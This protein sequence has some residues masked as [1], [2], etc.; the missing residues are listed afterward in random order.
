MHLPVYSA[1]FAARTPPRA[2]ACLTRLRAEF[3]R[4]FGLDSDL[5]LGRVVATIDTSQNGSV[6]LREFLGACSAQA[7]AVPVRAWLTRPRAS[8]AGMS[9]FHSFSKEDRDKRVRR[10][11]FNMMDVTGSGII[12][13]VRWSKEHGR[14]GAA[15]ARLFVCHHFDVS[16]AQEHLKRFAALAY[17]QFTDATSVRAASVRAH[18]HDQR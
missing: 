18:T 11:A 15:L 10:F 4:Q 3:S 16:F 2:A 14:R 12:E 6:D 13:R 7:A 17:E 1:P 9:Q 5:F 8:V